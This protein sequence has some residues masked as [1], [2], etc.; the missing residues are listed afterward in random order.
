MMLKMMSR[1]ARLVVRE[2]SS[3][4][5]ALW[6]MFD[7]DFEGKVEVVACADGEEGFNFQ[8]RECEAM[9]APLPQGKAYVILGL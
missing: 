7:L 9:E 1:K 2:K 6:R 8:F 3:E 4:D 5:A